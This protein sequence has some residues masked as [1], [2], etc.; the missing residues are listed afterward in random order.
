MY[1]LKRKIMKI[2]RILTILFFLNCFISTKVTAQSVTFEWQPDG[3][4][5]TN[6]GEMYEVIPFD[7]KSAE[8]LY[9]NLMVSV[10]SIYNDPNQTI[11]SVEN[12]LISV[13]AIHEVVWDCGGILGEVVVNFHYTLKLHIKDAKVKVDAPHFTLLT[14]STGGSQSNIE[15]W[16]KAQK[17]FN[18]DGTPNP[19]KGK[20]EF[21]LRVNTSFNSLINNI[22]NIENDN[23]DW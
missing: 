3:S 6:N 9:D 16:V 13:Y 1:N 8:E 2:I 4:M 14:F 10:S 11:S 15:G 5:L 21:C 23:E 17:F 19:K 7:G 18:E 12:K 22:I 20:G